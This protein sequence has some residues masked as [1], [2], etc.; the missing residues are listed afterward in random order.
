MDKIGFNYADPVSND[1]HM[2]A[3]EMKVPSPRNSVVDVYFPADGRTL[4]YLN[5]RFDL[6]VGDVVFVEGSMKDKVG[7]VADIR[8][9][10]RV[11]KSE[12][13]HIISRA[14]TEVHGT[15]YPAGSN[16]LTFDPGAVN[17][18][19]IRTWFFPPVA[20]E[21]EF[22]EGE[23]DYT[24]SLY[25]LGD[26]RVT[27]LIA[28]RGQEY[29]SN[30][31]VLYLCMDAAAGY[32][33]VDGTSPYEVEFRCEDGMISNLK[34]SCFCSFDCKHE[35]AVMLQLKEILEII[36]KNYSFNSDKL[37]YFALINRSVFFNYAFSATE[38]ASF[39]V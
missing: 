12:Y 29:Y 5:T 11:R 1:T 8:Y 21:D 37:S 24:F 35:V 15:F 16:F 33:I 26:M 23:D 3:V 7:R 36:E 17:R 10:F 25:N 14:D 28:G 6:S 4:A 34:C 9:G 13:K 30:S 38:G 27:P 31:R 18:E 2:E 20:D 39:T 22:V 32:A 19:K